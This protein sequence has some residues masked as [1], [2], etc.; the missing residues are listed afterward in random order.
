MANALVIY[1]DK[2]KTN[3]WARWMVGRVMRQN[4]NNLIG[5]VGPTGSG[6]T[7]TG[8]SI[9]EI[10]SG[11][12]G[13]H[14]GI[15]HIVFSL[16]ELMDLINGGTL[17]KGSTI[18]FDEPQ[19]SISSRDFQADANKVF[20]LLLST[21]RHRNLTLIFCTPFEKLLD[22]NTRKLFHARFDTM[23]I[24]RN[25]NT[26]R[27]KPRFV[28]YSDFKE[29]PYRKQLI[30]Q[31]R[32]K[33]GKMKSEKVFYWDVP[34]PDAEIIK[35]YEAKKLAFTDRI[36]KNISTRLKK[37]DESGKSITAEEQKID[38]RKELTDNQ[39]NIL[40]S[41]AKHGNL[42][43]VMKELNINSPSS[44]SNAVKLA[45]NKGYRVEDFKKNE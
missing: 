35:L 24:N 20:N 37:Y 45:R 22:K 21:F 5:L 38:T 1:R 15:E 25:D 41:L 16:R 8:I 30:V 44:I 10:M 29:D 2:K 32:N 3:S 28:E 36:N 39:K 13:V 14:F 7:Y 42:K 27:I 23:S 34:K 40:M 43:D 18:I 31:Y 19:A 26:C 9:A 17:R 6:K 33:E 11:M 12:S 4:K